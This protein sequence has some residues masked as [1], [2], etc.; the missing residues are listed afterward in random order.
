MPSGASL[1]NRAMDLAAATP[2]FPLRTVLFPG[3]LLPLRIFELRYLDMIGRCHRE[4]APFG[5]V[6]LTQGEEVRRR[7][8]PQPGQPEG[9][10]FERESFEAVGTLAR[11]ADLQR[12][13]AGLL[14]VRCIGEQRFKVLRTGQRGHG[15]WVAEIEPVAGDAP[16]PVPVDLARLATALQAVTRQLRERFDSDESEMPFVQPYRWDD[17]GWLANRWCEL[18]P[19]PLAHKQQLMALA[20]PLVRLELVADLLDRSDAR[21]G[22]DA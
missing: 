2:L 16:V 9:G 11:I 14:V 22:S 19:L 18:L 12:V 1:Q 7:L 6:C 13:Q 17:C 4:G 8:P 10:E 20:N 5:V 15:L 3:G 21:T